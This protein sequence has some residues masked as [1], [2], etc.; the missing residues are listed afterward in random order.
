MNSYELAQQNFSHITDELMQ[1][2]ENY[3]RFLE[4]D[5]RMYSHSFSDS[6]LVY[7]QNPNA[8]RVAELRDWNAVGRYVRKGEHSIVSFADSGSKCKYLFDVS[9]TQGKSEPSQWR[10][11]ADI[12][13]RIKEKLDKAFSLDTANLDETIAKITADS[14]KNS[15]QMGYFPKFYHELPTEQKR[16]FNRSLL[17]ASRFVTATRCMQNGET[18]LERTLDLNAL[19][20]LKN[21]DDFILY[22]SIVHNTAQNTLK[23][24]EDK[25]LEAVKDRAR[26]EDLVSSL[27]FGIGDTFEINST[28]YAVENINAHTSVVTL[29]DIAADEDSTLDMSVSELN[30]FVGQE[31]KEEHKID[32]AIDNIIGTEEDIPIIANE[33]VTVSED[34][35]VLDDERIINAVLASDDL[36]YE[37]KSDITDFFGYTSDM[38]ERTE[39]ISSIYRDNGEIEINGTVYGIEKTDTGLNIYEGTSDNRTRQS[40]MSFEAVS[41]MLDEMLVTQ[42]ISFDEP[43]TSFED[44]D[45]TELSVPDRR[46]QCETPEE[47]E[48]LFNA[49]RADGYTWIDGEEL[50]RTDWNYGEENTYYSLNEEG[51]TLEAGNITSL[52]PEQIREYNIEKFSDISSEFIVGTDI[53]QVDE[54]KYDLAY[55]PR[56]DRINVFDL[57]SESREPIAFITP[58]RYVSYQAVVPDSVKRSIT[59]YA[60]KMPPMFVFPEIRKPL[61]GEP[62][63]TIP[64]SEIGYFPKNVSMPFS[65]ANEVFDAAE[66]HYIDS[67][68]N[69]VT[70]DDY[71]GYAKTDFVIE[72]KINGEDFTY[73]GRFDI[74]DGQETL[75]NHIREEYEYTLQMYRENPTDDPATLADREKVINEYERITSYLKSYEVYSP[76]PMEQAMNAINDF[77][78]S[79]YSSE[80]DFSDM[81]NVNIAYTTI[82]EI[83]NK[84]LA[85]E[86]ELQ[87]SVD[88]ENYAINSYVDGDLIHSET[89]DSIEA[90]LPALNNLDFNELTSTI[91]YEEEI[92][93][94]LADKQAERAID[95]NEALADP[96]GS[97]EEKAELQRELDSLTGAEQNFIPTRLFTI[98]QND[99]IQYFTTDK[100]ADELLSIAANSDSPF[101]ELGR[102]GNAISE[103]DYA[104]LEQADTFGFSVDI[105]LNERTAGIYSVNF[106]M[107]GVSELNRDE[108][109][110][111]IIHRSLSEYVKDK[112]TPDRTAYTGLG[113]ER[114]DVSA[115][116]AASMWEN[117]FEVYVDG[118]AVEPH[119]PDSSMELFRQ[120]RAFSAQF[121]DVKKQQMIDF[122][123]NE[124]EELDMTMPEDKYVYVRDFID[125]EEDDPFDWGDGQNVYLNITRALIERKFDFIDDYLTSV[126]NDYDSI[127]AE[128]VQDVLFEYKHYSPPSVEYTTV[129]DIPEYNF[130]VDLKNIDELYLKNDYSYYEGGID[131][132][133]HERKDN[134]SRQTESLTITLDP[135]G[136]AVVERYDSKSEYNIV[137]TEYDLSDEVDVSELRDKVS[138]FIESSDELSI[139]SK[140]EEVS[141][142]IQIHEQRELTNREKYFLEKDLAP[143]LVDQC[144]AYDEVEDLSYVLFD[145]DLRPQHSTGTFG[146]GL[147][148][149]FA[150]ELRERMRNGEDISAELGKAILGKVTN[151]RF[152]PTVSR[153]VTEDVKLRHDL[154]TVTV[155]YGDLQHDV[156]YSSVGAEVI[157]RARE[158]H[159]DI[160]VY[161]ATEDGILPDTRFTKLDD[162][163]RMFFDLHQ[164]VPQPET[165]PWGE[166]D[167]IHEINNGIFDVSTPSHGGIM[168]K[169]DIAAKILTKEARDIAFKEDGFT[170]FE[171]D[172]AAAVAFRELIDKDMFRNIDDYFRTNYDTPWEKKRESFN[173]SIDRTLR[174]YYPDYWTKRAETIIGAVSEEKQ[175]ELSGQMMF[176][177]EKAYSPITKEMYHPD[178]ADMKWLK[179][180]GEDVPALRMDIDVSDELFERLAENGLVKNKYSLDRVMVD[181][182][183]D[184]WKAI[185]IPDSYGNVA[186]NIPA[187]TV[188]TFEEMQTYNEVTSEVIDRSRNSRDIEQDNGQ[189]VM[190]FEPVPQNIEDSFDTL[191]V[192]AVSETM[193]E[194]VW[195]FL[196]DNNSVYIGKPQNILNGTYDNSDNSLVKL[197]D[198]EKIY[199]FLTVGENGFEQSQ[200]QMLDLRRMSI[201][202]YR[203]I[204]HLQETVLSSYEQKYD[205]KFAMER[206]KAVSDETV[207]VHHDKGKAQNYRTNALDMATGGQVGRFLANVKAIETLRTLEKEN[208]YATQEEQAVLAKYSGWGGL[209][210]AFDSR[211]AAWGGRYNQLKELLTDSEYREAR[212]SITSAFYT[213]ESVKNAVYQG[214]AQL[215]FSGGEVLEPSCGI[216]GFI[217]AMPESMADH[218]KIHGVELD[219][220]SGR[221]AKKLYPQSDIQVKGFEKTTF[222]DNSFDVVIGNIPFGD[223]SVNDKDYNKHNFS[224]HDYFA[225]KT[226][227][228]V[229]PNGVV[230]IVTSKFT[231]DK[232]DERLRKYLAERATLLGAVRLPAGTF[233]GA[234]NVTTDILFLQKKE[235]P[236]VDDPSWVHMSQTADGIPCN[237][238]F[239]EHPEMILGKMEF[240][241]RM[242]GK[243][244][245]DSK[246]TVCSPL[247]DDDPIR[248]ENDLNRAVA[249]IKG[250][251]DT[252]R[253][254][255]TPAARTADILPADPDVR[256]FTHTMVNG[257][258]YFRKNDEMIRVSE[259]G[260]RLERMIGLHEIREAVFNVINAQI[261]DCSD[262]ELKALQDKLNSV[263]DRFVKKN[264]NVND[265]A[266]RNVF[267]SDDDYNTL[268]ALEVADK[269]TGKLVKADIFS[270]RT[271]LAVQEIT[272]VETAEEA[273][274]MSIEQKGKVDIGYMAELCDKK[275]EDIISEL[276]DS[277][278]KDPAKADESIPFSGYVEK[279]EYLSGNVRERLDLARIY[280]KSDPDYERNVKALEEAIPPTIEAP[281]ITASIGVSWVD[282]ED[283]S[284]FFKEEMNG[285]M[286][287]HTMRRD[288]SGEYHVEHARNGDFDSR[289][290]YGTE[291][292][293]SYQ[294]FE[295]LLNHRDITVKD[296]NED[297]KPIPNLK[298]TEKARQKAEEMKRAFSAW[299]F[300]DFDRRQKYVE[301]Y[302]RLF[303]SI[304]GRTYD[305]SR[306]TFPNMN[307]NIKLRAHQLDAVMRGKLGGNT[308]LAHCVG[309]GKSFEMDTIVMEKKRL[310]LISKAC[311]VVPKHLTMQTALEWQRLYP[312]AKLLVATPKDFEKNKRQEFLAKCVTG[313]YDAVIMSYEQFGK[314]GMSLE[315]QENFIQKQ[316]NQLE[317]AL[318]DARDKGNSISVSDIER[319]KKR[320]KTRLEKLNEKPR[321][322]SLTF[323][324]MGFDY[325]VVDEAHNYKNCLVISKMS[326]VSGVQTTGAA[327][328]EDMLM[329]GQY[330]T[331]RYGDSTQLWATGTPISN[332]MV[333]LY[334]MTRYLR[335]D[336]LQK[337]G[338][339]NFDD[340]AG[341][342]GNVV[343]Q[344]E[345]KPAGDGFRMKKRFAEFVNL[346]ELMQMYKEF[347]DI[348]MGDT[349]S[350]PN[351]PTMKGGKVQIVKS[352]IDELQKE[353][354]KVLAQRSE[355]IHSGGV[356]SKEDNMLKVTHEARLLGLDGRTINPDWKPDPDCKVMKLCDNLENIYKETDKDKGV[357]IVFCDIAIHDTNG[358]FS[359]YKA[360]KDELESRGIPRDEVCFA[361]DAKND[362]ERTKMFEQ[363]RKGEKRV[364]IAS[365]SK[366]GTGANIQDRIAAI[367]HLDIPWKPSDLEQQNG[368]GLRQ[369]NMYKEVGIYQYVTENTFDA[370]MLGI[371]TA[372][373]KFISQVMTSKNVSRTCKDV[374]E[375][376][377]NYAEMQAIASGNPLLAKKVQLEYDVAT[378]RMLNN[379]HTKKLFELDDMVKRTLP[380]SIAK[381]TELLAKAQDDLNRYKGN[382]PENSEDFSIKLN[383]TEFTERKEAAQELEKLINRCIAN[384]GSLSVGEYS[385]FKLS[386]EK[387]PNYGTMGYIDG[388]V[389]CYLKMQGEL[390]YECP[391]KI[392]NGTGNITRIENL[393]ENTIAK[394]T[395]DIAESLQTDKNNL[396]SAKAE[397]DKPFS[398][399]DELKAKEQELAE[400][401]AE[402]GT[403]KSDDV[404]SVGGESDDK[405]EEQ[406]IGDDEEIDKAD[407][408]DDTMAIKGY[409]ISHLQKKAQSQ[410]IPSQNAPEPPKAKK[411]DPKL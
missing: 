210:Q 70:A 206:F 289:M 292:M 262:K 10:I 272:H 218:S 346:P 245:E 404:I 124:I 365:T 219:S 162:E 373:A 253:T 328:S 255:S 52:T 104:E 355:R 71:M 145:N 128:R 222:A 233:S 331:E 367:H 84:P 322:E 59:D 202:D 348:R 8:S 296:Y 125:E 378:L 137:Q 111:R 35:P 171:E 122:I 376:V 188:L 307:P 249:N 64:F 212:A 178:T 224:I 90:M 81:S 82:V 36:R 19:S 7:R 410:D 337:A 183:G 49:L 73:R 380:N 15:Y 220:I 108:S 402:L 326:N 379:E 23:L 83:D 313:E 189:M 293:N 48:Q 156:P 208:R 163:K 401:N 195:A 22:A 115:E 57:N 398:Q 159:L 148:G 157:R 368:R 302:N 107:G 45:F 175:A 387:N 257:Q 78:V 349:V 131:S 364:I 4:F 369:G 91:D 358:R 168:I 32:T 323:E 127:R 197:S 158:E 311:V 29:R 138:N 273:L 230:A 95:I 314:I 343:T 179:I 386:I 261:E 5:S 282:V 287:Y 316:I 254:V 154:D 101:I 338:L 259:T 132:D 384:N 213:P 169:N 149:E 6:V 374:D 308:L 248:F 66:T 118:E 142:D 176:G 2:R 319:Q 14:I 267:G 20:F 209:S 332:S 351:I 30:S 350:I 121:G 312:T 372:K 303:N 165:S 389:P 304:V 211:N 400:V 160:E 60:Q 136:T 153:W 56:P 315:Y 406:D 139:T 359:V 215:G 105:D 240:D 129:I 370:Y 113:A 67:R 43:E 75:S 391:L 150:V 180:K 16:E 258:L 227:D 317:N 344:L 336:L 24:V 144:L 252:Q 123:S 196:D 112:D 204:T 126:K 329:K 232:Q 33:P 54:H 51:K 79:E 300:K 394:R 265:K 119:T 198:N 200:Q 320:L 110:S 1:S 130:Y 238:Y 109:N 106:G 229:K 388:D 381:K 194:G 246:I 117:G 269:N 294:I 371:I 270:K 352:P 88:L 393:P 256:N 199:D 12:A 407:K 385:G 25:V 361:G 173:D 274:H 310:G 366:L 68:N 140:K 120:D 217:G 285:N 405:S 362:A 47:A 397:L 170:C 167:R 17:S 27:D 409:D 193:Y 86:L 186:N 342:F 152:H 172:C 99:T 299:L 286:N 174:S 46:I 356:D 216:G 340:W 395:A 392:N 89:Y 324:Q 192:H 190:G 357:Q 207:M 205:L 335:P 61:Q 164:Y 62:M 44:I 242:Q 103:S 181:V 276:G 325:L 318:E 223:F 279:S 390:T 63:V 244:G 50:E 239:T 234:D 100:T 266:N 268:C 18:E 264:G 353:Y 184:N 41:A 280:A 383:G 321:D 87:V 363:L 281:D 13:E 341:N 34:I 85:D 347:A 277:I 9:Q 235:R 39:Y 327:K 203:E 225:A 72:G 263:Y 133:G 37:R 185:C 98:Q 345:M 116:Y 375:M 260:K 237:K 243:Y 228:K 187:D 333:E 114:I 134:F 146:N 377:L 74:G 330:M 53:A 141:T 26:E 93:S 177:Q 250:T 271:I 65:Q 40:G 21:R 241:K 297:K 288:I 305:G 69:T 298:E 155:I 94:M 92:Q 147:S 382:K 182:V 236:S 77:C 334:S 31:Q 42:D 306:Q 135:L 290:K 201:E 284:K 166:I 301:R 151:S 214:L 161:R 221:I 102:E 283:Y 231:M 278:Y 399:A 295:N 191:E 80:A 55:T 76:D 403:D 38:E 354:M 11:D 339:Q 291:R 247:Y 3:I 251:I 411:H 360:I 226:I 408:R 309:A 275:E 58:N 96:I 396:E 28:I 97:P 143:D